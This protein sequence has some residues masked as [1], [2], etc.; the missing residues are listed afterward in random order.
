MVMEIVK[1]NGNFKNDDE[2]TAFFRAV[3][4]GTVA[5]PTLEAVKASKCAYI[6]AMREQAC[7]VDVPALGYLWQA[8]KR[9]KELL[10]G[11]IALANAGVP[12]PTV[13]RTTDNINVAISSIADL[14]AIAG[15]IALQ[16]QSAYAHSWA[17]K[18]DVAAANDVGGVVL[19]TW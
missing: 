5:E 10:S 8:D 15:A 9:S 1:V 6:D 3:P 12:L 4:S 7:E 16:V 13:W 11:A 14:L 17:L 19:I 2:K 18:G